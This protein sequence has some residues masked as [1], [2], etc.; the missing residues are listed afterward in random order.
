VAA[1]LLLTAVVLWIL[2]RRF[3]GG[4]AFASIVG[5][6]SPAWVAVA[7]VASCACVLIGAER[8]RL[9]LA[10]MGYELPFRRSLEVVLA[11]WPLTMVTPSRA[12]DL[13]RPVAVRNVVPLAVG[14][15]SVLAE[16]AMDLLVL[17]LYAACGAAVQR[18]WVWAAA[19]GA[20][21]GAEVI[22]VAMILANRGW[23][24][25][26]PLLRRRRD[27]I[28]ALFRA[29]EALRHAR[30]RLVGPVVASFAMRVLTVGII[31]ALLVSVGARP[32]LFDTMTL[33]PS[34]T[35]VGLAPLTFAGVGTRDA[36]FIELI[37]A[38]GVRLDPSQV[39]AATVGYSAIAIALF[40]IVGVPFMIAEMLRERR[41]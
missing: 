7:M 20:L 29:L 28:E 16:K 22:A 2:L 24:E 31:H 25:R 32:R 3:G 11:T 15:G 9:V 23:V 5:S 12:N 14:T 18:L 34:A 38:R 13:L 41:A 39:L 36:A 19:I 6:A 8:W 35:L 40:A 30:L 37:A 21:A 4:T 33:W 26:L 17:L 10:A 27:A 1:T